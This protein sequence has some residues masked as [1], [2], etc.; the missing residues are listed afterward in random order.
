MRP[1]KE[2]W[3]GAY[4]RVRQSV[5]RPAAGSW[6]RGVPSSS[7]RRRTRTKTPEANSKQ[8]GRHEGDERRARRETRA[9]DGGGEVQGALRGASRMQGAGCRSAGGR[10][11]QQWCSAR[12]ESHLKK[13]RKTSTSIAMFMQTQLSGWH[14]GRWCKCA[15][16]A[17][18]CPSSDGGHGGDGGSSCAEGHRGACRRSS[19]RR[20][21]WSCQS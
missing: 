4:T 2:S 12:C 21:E 7:R 9:G 17:R 5:P 20:G 16:H 15:G 13:G 8:T 18:G 14:H 3:R 10:R 1:A 19:A 11:V 6:K